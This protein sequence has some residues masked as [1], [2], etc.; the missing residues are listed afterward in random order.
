MKNNLLEEVK[1]TA[2]EPPSGMRSK[3]KS[4]LNTPFFQTFYATNTYLFFQINSGII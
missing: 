3:I 2:K 4:W 1:S